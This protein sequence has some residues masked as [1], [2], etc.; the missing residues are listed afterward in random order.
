MRRQRTPTIQTETLLLQPSLSAP[1]TLH[2]TYTN[3]SF[4]EVLTVTDSLGFV[5]TN[6]YD[7]KGN[8]LSVTT[9]DP[10]IV[11]PQA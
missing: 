5:K 7:S 8:L 11:R 10:G 9:P 2:T 1:G 4:G 3:N 6:T